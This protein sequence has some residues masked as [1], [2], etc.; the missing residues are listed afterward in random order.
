MFPMNELE[1]TNT[2]VPEQGATMKDRGIVLLVAAAVILL[3]QL[4]KYIVIQTL[5]LYQSWAP[6]PAL[7]AFFQITHATNTGTAFGLFPNVGWLFGL[8]AVVVSGAIIYFNERIAS[9]NI[10]LRVA[11]GLELGGALGNLIDRV[12]LGYVTD[13]LDF[14]PWP[15]FNLADLAIVS[16]AVLLAWI[17]LREER[18]AKK[19]AEAEVD[20]LP[21]EQS[22]TEN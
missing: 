11:L 8:M 18:E 6:I 5:P 20:S 21:E 15:V 17:V 1:T 9:G 10:W 3:D 16:G 13:L 4:S 7:A 12:R 14:G 2:A 19:A 22:P